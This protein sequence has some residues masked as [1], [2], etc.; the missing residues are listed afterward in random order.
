MKTVFKLCNTFVIATLLASLLWGGSPLSSRVHAAGLITITSNA[1]TTG[2]D[3]VCTLREAITNANN[4]AGTYGDCAAGSG[5]DTLTFATALAG[6]VISLATIGDT[7]LGPTA[8]GVTSNITILG[9]SN[10]GITIERSSSAADMRLFYVG[11]GASLTLKD[12]TLQGGIARGYDGGAALYG[13]TGGGAAGVGGA[14]FNRGTLTL[15]SLTLLNNQ[16]LGGNGAVWFPISNNMKWGGGGGGVG[17]AGSASYNNSAG[18][19]PN[20]GAYTNPNNNGATGAGGGGGGGADILNHYTAG[21]GGDFGGG[22]GGRSAGRDD[23]PPGGNG[24]FGGGGGGG[25]ATGFLGPGC[26]ISGLGGVSTYGGGTGGRGRCEMTSDEHY[27]G[28]GGGGAGM[29]GALFNDAGGVVTVVNSTLAANTARGG[30]GGDNI[31]LDINLYSGGGGSGLGG[32]IF[33]RAGTLTLLNATLAGNTVTAGAAGAADDASYQGANGTRGGSEVYTYGAAG[34]V[35]VTNTIMANSGST[36][37]YFVNDSSTVNGSHNLIMRAN[38]IPAGVIASSADPLL[39]ALADNGGATQTQA[40]ASGSPAINTGTGSGAPVLDQRGAGRD[41]TPDMGAYEVMGSEWVVNSSADTVAADGVMTLR[42]A[43]QRANSP[44]GPHTIRFA[45]GMAGQ[46]IR[47]NATAEDNSFGPSAFRIDYAVM[48]DADGVTGILVQRDNAA[49]EMRLFYVAPGGSL[50]LKGITL[51][52]GLARGKNGGT[53]LSG[54]GGG[55]AGGLGGAIFNQGTLDLDGVTL[56]GNQ[57]IGGNG[58]S[59]AYAGGSGGGGGGGGLGSNGAD[60]GGYDGGA[61]GAP[62]GG[63]AGVVG[64]QNGSAGGV[65]G[66]G[67][68]GLSYLISPPDYGGYNG[69]AGGFGGGGGGG[70]GGTSF[71]QKGVG[72]AGGFGGGAGGNSGNQYTDVSG[73]FGGG[74]NNYGQSGGG[75]AGMG[76]AIFNHA[77]TVSLTNTTLSANSAQGGSSSSAFGGSALGGAIFNRAGSV[78][79]TNSTLAFNTLAGSGTRE[80]G[81]LYSYADGGAATTTLVNSILSNSSGGS[82]AVNNGGTLSGS[83]N[84]IMNASGLSSVTLSNASPNLGGLANNGGPTFTHAIVPPS[85]ALHSGTP[86]GAPLVD[87][88]GISR[89]TRP[90]IGA[91]ELQAAITFA[92]PAGVCGGNIPCFTSIS[93]AIGGATEGGFANVYGGAYTETPNLNKNITASLLGDVTLNGSFT[94]SAGTFNGGPGNLTITE[95]FTQS[96]GVLTTPGG[97]LVISGNSARA[98]GTVNYTANGTIQET[99]SISG[100]P[101]L[102]FAFCE[103]GVNVTGNT[104]LTDL[105]VV[106]HEQGHNQATSMTD[107][108]WNINATGSGT[109]TLT[110]PQPNLANPQVCR[111][112]GGAG[113]GWDCARNGFSSTAVWRDGIASFSDWAVGT[114]APTAVRLVSY[115]AHP[116]SSGHWA[117]VGIGLIL[118]LLGL[119]LRKFQK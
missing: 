57:A 12:L 8:L 2:S 93:G 64:S 92:D 9:D 84:I 38:G 104:D 81:A 87:Q 17:S 29:G 119:A 50:T 45:A 91:F 61:G 111:H 40:P 114:Q 58:L 88:R 105:Q 13:G 72:G 99:R 101:S 76:G 1:D 36:F 22:G 68:G 41:E 27:S 54:G 44:L 67:G 31:E 25:G 60:S 86:T 43:I 35:N 77:G 32:A 90:D 14:I 18:G 107:L 100:L 30:N 37:D 19:G 66:G 94:L 6:S 117:W 102:T 48:I 69:G 70:G 20:G 24:G 16:A 113:G 75:G 96:G 52:N 62:N 85:P 53:S 33:N 39:G 98:G 82:D 112:T 65:G 7:T 28:S 108:Y 78:T 116:A 71:Y 83:H 95:N 49:S 51:S 11:A 73:G 97:E 79:L 21:N 63:A 109:I 42:E 103:V 47:L 15:D 115:T 46:T 74:N 23:G 26:S 10:E 106:R 34:V 4:D 118:P 5:A 80:G 89:D 110:L 59:G 55:G 3:G 56:T